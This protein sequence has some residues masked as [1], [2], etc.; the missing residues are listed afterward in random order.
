MLLNLLMNSLFITSLNSG[1]NANCYY[2]GN[3]QEALLV[4]AGLSCRETEKR[5]KQLG[6]SLQK[7]KALFVSHEH[8]DHISGVP[9][10]SK[11]YQLPVYIT[12]GTF[13]NSSIPVEEPLLRHFRHTKTLEIGSLSVTPFRKSHDAADPHSFM[14][15]GHGINVG[16]ITDIGY[17]CKRVIKYFSQCDAAFLEANYCEDMLENGNY[18]YHLQQRI[19]GDEGHLSNAQALELFQH[20]RSPQLQLLVL[21]HLS[22]NNNKPE[23]VEKLFAPHANPTRIVIASRY[24]AS[25]VFEVKK[26]D[27]T[28]VEIKVKGKGKKRGN[29]QQLSLF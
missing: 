5:M 21:S 6:L 27:K 18:P 22:R 4:D 29:E 8:A 15:S 7:V 9:G 14:I 3:D 1:S 17:A 2:V 13:R 24:T 23:L 11:K 12:E 10:L 28:K 26:E 19:R 20:Y 16:V 25:E